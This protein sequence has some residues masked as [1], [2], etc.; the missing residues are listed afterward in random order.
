M[1]KVFDCESI[2]VGGTD[3]DTIG[4]V[5]SSSGSWGHSHSH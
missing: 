4:E 1:K 3:N 5:A 2:V